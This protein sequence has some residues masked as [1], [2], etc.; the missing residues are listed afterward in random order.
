MREAGPGAG[1][2][3]E[4][5]YVLKMRWAGSRRGRLPPSMWACRGTA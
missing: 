3:L 1:R 2:Y 5:L 4:A